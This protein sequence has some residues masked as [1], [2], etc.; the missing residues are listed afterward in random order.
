MLTQQEIEVF[1]RREIKAKD[2]FTIRPIDKTIAYD[3]VRQYHYLGEAKFFAKYSYGLFHK[4][5]L[6]GVASFACPQG[7]EALHGWFGLPNDNKTVM[8]LTRLCMLPC[9]NGTNATSYLL[10]GGDAK[11][12]ARG[13]TGGYNACYV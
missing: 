8:E 6:C 7:S 5:D 4:Y 3:F 2:I 11:A 1:A 12:K 9:L 10:G 13:H